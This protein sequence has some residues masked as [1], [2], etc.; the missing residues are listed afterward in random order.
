[1]RILAIGD[2]HGKFPQKLINLAKKED[3]DLVVSSGDFAS[4]DKIREIIFKNWAKP[5]YESIGMKQAAKLEKESFDSGLKILKKINHIGKK[6]YVIWGNSDFY[7]DYETSEPPMI[8]PG[9]YDDKIKKLKN[10]I[11]ID[12]KRKKVSGV[13]MIGHGGY[14]DVTEFIR[15][16]VDKDKKKQKKRLKR[17]LKTAERLE[18]LVRKYKPETGFIFLI[19][20]TPYKCLDKVKMKS[21][22]MNGKPVGFEPY[23]EIIKRYHPALVICG[24]MHENPGTCKIGSSVIVNPGA[25]SEGRAAIIDFDTGKKRVLNIRFLK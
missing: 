24:H 15:N 19:H 1:M 16:P 2:F 22:P 5:W 12:K 6:V 21:S 14:L 8:M 10:L 13:E 7:R 11:L 25:A 17:Y 20:Y 18:K 9:Y 23:N 3:I 4:T